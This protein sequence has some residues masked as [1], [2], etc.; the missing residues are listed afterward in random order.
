MSGDDKRPKPKAGALRRSL[1]R[2]AAVQA[3]Y[4][5][6][7]TEVPVDT[8][9]AEF[10][11]R[12]DDEESFGEADDELFE[13]LVRGATARRAEIDEL[14]SSVLTPDWPLARLEV[15][16]R[17]VLRG[18]A[19]ELVARLEVPARVIIN[20]YMELAHAF[21]SGKEP[22]MVNGVLDKLAHRLRASELAEGRS[23]GPP[24]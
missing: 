2:L 23:G 24:R 11:N 17:A 19:Y 13:D 21:F 15:V 22:G 3:L 16:L 14:I 9:L 8:V 10:R 6:D 7:L 12:G 18:G 20:E 5:I 1:A 4:Q